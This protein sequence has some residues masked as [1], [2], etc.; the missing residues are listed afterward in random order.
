M[1]FKFLIIVF[2]P[3]L[4]SAQTNFTISGKIGNLNGQAKIHLDYTDNSQGHTD[5]VVLVNGTP[6]QQKDTAAMKRSLLIPMCRVRYLIKCL[7]E[8]FKN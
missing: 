1:K 6:A 4:A 8:I 2:L 7:A 3:F 5:S